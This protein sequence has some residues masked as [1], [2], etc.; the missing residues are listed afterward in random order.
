[1]ITIYRDTTREKRLKSNTFH[2][3]YSKYSRA[4][5]YIILL[6]S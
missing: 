4:Y 3:F 1:M 5:E 6:I 2:I